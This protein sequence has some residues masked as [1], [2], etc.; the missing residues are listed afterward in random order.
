MIE[1]GISLLAVPVF[2]TR[3]MAFSRVSR[4]CH[5]AGSPEKGHP[6]STRFLCRVRGSGIC[7]SLSWSLGS[8]DSALVF[9]CI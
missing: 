9:S 4:D 7:G 6:G 2:L 3:G 1:L 8:E 5:S